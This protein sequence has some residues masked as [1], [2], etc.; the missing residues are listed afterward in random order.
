MKSRQ[1]KTNEIKT[2][3]NKTST[4]IKEKILIKTKNSKMMNKN[5]N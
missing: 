2:N 1:M 3:E 4:R 5:I